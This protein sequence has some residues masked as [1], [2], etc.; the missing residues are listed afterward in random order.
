MGIPQVFLVY[1][2]VVGRLEDTKKSDAVRKTQKYPWDIGRKVMVGNDNDH[3][4]CC[5]KCK[6]DGISR[7]VYKKSCEEKVS[8]EFIFHKLQKRTVERISNF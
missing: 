6:M 5:Y 1:K 2:F 7:N 3:T 8:K 4:F